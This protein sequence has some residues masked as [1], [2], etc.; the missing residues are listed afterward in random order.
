MDIKLNRT[1]KVV[2]MSMK[3][4]ILEAIEM[5]EHSLKENINNPACKNLF[6]TYKGNLQS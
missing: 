1:N 3:Y 6:D 2:E 4:H 5:F